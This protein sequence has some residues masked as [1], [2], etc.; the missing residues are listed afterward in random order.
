MAGPFAITTARN[1]VQLNDARQGSVTFTVSNQLN[2]PI[3]G[4]ARVAPVGSTEARWLTLSGEEERNFQVSDTR[5]F[6][7]EINVPPEAPPGQYLLRL[8][9]IGVENPDEQYSEGPAVSFVVPEEEKKPFPWWIVAVAGGLVLLIIAVVAVILLSGGPEL[10]FELAPQEEVVAGAAAPY[11]LSI[12]NEGRD[13][14]GVVTNISLSEGVIFVTEGQDERCGGDVETLTCELGQIDDET[15]AALDF[16]IAVD[17]R[18]RGEVTV[19]AATTVGDDE[20]AQIISDTVQVVVDAV[21]VVS[22]EGPDTSRVGEEMVFQGVVEN[23]GQSA[24]TNVRASY[25]LPD[26]VTLLT[27]PEECALEATELVCEFEAIGPSRSIPLGLV[28]TAG[29]AAVG[30]LTTRL[31]AT[32]GEGDAG[33]QVM[34]NI[35][36]NE[37]LSITINQPTENNNNFLAGNTV[38]FRLRVSNN[39]TRPAPDVVVRYVLPE[40]TD[41]D[42]LLQDQVVDIRSCV[43]EVASREVICNVGD[44]AS[45][46]G[47][48]IEIHVIPEQVALVEHTFG[49]SSPSFAD[50][51]VSLDLNVVEKRVCAA[52]C[53]FTAVQAAIDAAA[54]GDIIGIDAGTYGGNITVNKNVH[55]LGSQSGETILDKGNSS[56]VLIVPAGVVATVERLII[57]TGRAPQGT[58]AS[59]DHAQGGPGQNGGGVYN[60]GT[61]TMING[62]VRHNIAGTGGTGG[63]GGGEGGPGGRGGGIYNNGV[64]HLENMEIMENIAGSG[65]TGGNGTNT[66]GVPSTGGVGG[67]GGGIYNAGTLVMNDSSLIGNRA[68]RG[69]AGGR[70]LTPAQQPG[71]GGPGGTVGGLLNEGVQEGE[72]NL[73]SGNEA[74][75]AGA[76]GCYI[77]ADCLRLTITDF[78]EEMEFIDDSI[79]GPALPGVRD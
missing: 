66:G 68:G 45:G 62:I 63:F 64:L 38:T 21:L 2:R 11:T 22:L 3:F 74:G 34:T 52:G 37:G 15:P 18:E 25:A 48:T 27:P 7:V 54:V 40:G 70:S 47:A 78:A 67:D 23:G 30:Q 50:A 77:E 14:E 49:V 6:T 60:E 79:I 5:Q 65:G 72:N 57:Q 20:E 1:D 55:L 10:V 53:P 35:L 19:T 39:T 24:L 71:F 59:T 31:E 73:V 13:A 33:D 28:L 44:L 76:N 26:G 4:R 75:S 29:P 58:N 42:M 69:G 56:R 8:D 16:L 9:M 17:G 46:E 36:P 41:F 51:S 12:T 32:S 61:L 43:D